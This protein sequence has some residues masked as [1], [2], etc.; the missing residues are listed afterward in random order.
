M[1]SNPNHSTGIDVANLQR[2]I[3]TLRHSKNEQD[4]SI[5]ALNRRLTD[6]IGKIEEVTR[7]V[8]RLE[9]A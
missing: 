8:E 2:Q 1:H 9:R 4:H 3:E 5:E 6:A 7:R